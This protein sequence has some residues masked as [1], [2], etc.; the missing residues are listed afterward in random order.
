MSVTTIKARMRERRFAASV[1][2]L[3]GCCSSTAVVAQTGAII[4][5]VVADSARGHPVEN[6][7]IMAPALN[8]S[9]RS[10]A[11]GE[12]RLANL[13]PGRHLIVVRLIGYRTLT[14]SIE[15]GADADT[16]HNFVLSQRAIPLDSM[17]AEAKQPREYIS[18]NLN[19]FL[20]RMHNHAGGYFIDDSTL[21][22]NEDHHLQDV[23]LSRMAGM[24]LIRW[25]GDEAYLASSR[26]GSGGALLGSSG[27]KSNLNPL[28]RACYSTV[29]FDGILIYDLERMGRDVKPPDLS[30]ILVS[31]LAGVEFYPGQA[32]LPVQFK[33]GQCGTLLLWTREK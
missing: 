11:R 14:D 31:D 5:T 29:Y 3:I 33:S 28:P 18:P 23:V 1:A 10:N 2:M 22:K 13:A 24:R 20:E 27:S 15:L 25:A 16:R 8:V 9:V 17:V 19:G 30:A 6:A 21:R 12:F 26:M 32:S 7:E 4:G